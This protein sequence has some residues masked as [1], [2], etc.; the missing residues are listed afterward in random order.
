MDEI[1]FHLSN[2]IETLQIKSLVICQQGQQWLLMWLESIHQYLMNFYD[3]QSLQ[4]LKELLQQTINY[5]YNIWEQIQ[6]QFYTIQ[7]IPRDIYQQLEQ[8]CKT[9]VSRREI[10][11]GLIGI[12]VGTLI[13]YCIGINWGYTTRHLQHMK[14]VICHRYIGIEGA[15]MIDDAEIPSIYRSN[16]LLIQVRAASLNIIDTKICSGYS[17]MYRRLLNSGVRDEVM[18][19]VPS[20]APGTMAEYLICIESQIV[21]RPKIVPF[22][23]CASL[24]YNGCMAYDALV[25]KS[26]IQEGNAKGKKVLVYGGTTPIGCILIQLIKLWGGCVVSACRPHAIPIIKALGANDIIPLDESDIEK[27]LQI[28]EKFDA[29]FYTGGD[30]INEQTLKKYLLPYGTYV[31][32]IPEYL[33]SDTLGFFFGSIFTG[34][35]RIKLFFQ[36]IFGLDS[37]QWKDGIKINAMYLQILSD[38]AAAD[39]LQTV[40]EKVYAPHHIDQAIQH[41]LDPNAIGSTLIKFQ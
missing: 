28:H 25:N 34:W 6:F 4:S 8:L 20:W 22:E 35:V 3:Q 16:E 7:F 12:S 31:S 14:A 39:N 5:M 1:L 10:T 17:R 40:V 33:A 32:T 19:A 21:K 41:V 18:L 29:I 23:V 38:L 26:N 2:Q 27:N 11:F 9:N 13:G 24:P 37:L 15:S 30:P 36:Y